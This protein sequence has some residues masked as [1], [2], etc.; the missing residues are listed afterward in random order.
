MIPKTISVGIS[1]NFN[2]ISLGLISLSGSS[3]FQ[4]VLAEIMINGKEVTLSNSS[5][6]KKI[7]FFSKE[8]T[9]EV[10]KFT[11]QEAEIKIDGKNSTIRLGSTKEVKEIY[12]HVKEIVDVDNPEITSGTLIVGYNFLELES[13][14]ITFKKIEY[15][16]KT[17]LIKLG[18][19]H[20]SSA[21]ITSY[22][23]DSDI[24]YID[25]DP[26]I[27]NGTNIT[28]VNE[29]SNE[30]I[31]EV[32]DITQEETDTTT[33]DSDDIIEE[34]DKSTETYTIILASLV[35]IAM[36]I[37]IYFIFFKKKNTDNKS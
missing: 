7:K 35:V 5:N 9:I 26:V 1:E 14:G 20:G 19:A 12:V 18:A 31:D 37:S 17:Y 33:D 25:D 13:P 34:E 32:E 27:I 23:C 24:E 4:R 11:N 8:Y 29:T 22:S 2:G 16:N 15:G 10:E 21:Q 6:S 3:S 30:T 28:S 36:L